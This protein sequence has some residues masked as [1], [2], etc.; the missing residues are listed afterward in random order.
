MSVFPISF[1]NKNVVAL[2]PCKKKKKK[3]IS[4]NA[5]QALRTVQFHTN[6]FCT[7][8]IVHLF[9]RAGFSSLTL[10][11]FS[12]MINSS[13]VFSF[14]LLNLDKLISFFFF[15]I[16]IINMERGKLFKSFSA[17]ILSSC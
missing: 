12:V 14:L 17:L 2:C 16:I 4:S 7:V 5:K 9:L 15:F 1:K 6:V 10:N 11:L 13:F 3:Q 8:V